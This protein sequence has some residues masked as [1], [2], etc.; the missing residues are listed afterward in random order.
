MKEKSE[1]NKILFWYGIS[2][3]FYVFVVVFAFNHP[4]FF[5]NLTN[6]DGLIET[7]GTIGF[8]LASILFT[9]FTIKSK[10]L[11]EQKKGAYF[12]IICW[13]LVAFIAFGE[14]ISWGQRIFNVQL[15]EQY[16]VKEFRHFE[17]P[18]QNVQNE[19]NIHNMG[20][21]ES[22]FIAKRFQ[23]LLQMLPFFLLPLLTLIK[24]VRVF[25]HKIY[26]P[27]PS[28][29][30]IMW[31]AGSWFIGK[32]F[33]FFPSLIEG[34]F[35]YNRFNEFTEATIGISFMLFSIECLIHSTDFFKYRYKKQ[36]AVESK[37]LVK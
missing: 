18:M 10:E 17:G 3:I 30:L 37:V 28:L 5:S 7:T 4:I 22:S 24:K 34:T 14:E 1:F 16:Q 36:Q 6:E 15:P 9:V 26:L 11:R 35:D 33:R 29:Q 20:F 19:T 25:F 2:A 12:F 8:L 27:I 31:G 13:A 21:F 32:T 23:S